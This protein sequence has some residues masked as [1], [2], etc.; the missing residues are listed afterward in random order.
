MR[1]N[2]KCI[3]AKTLALTLALTTVAT[4]TP[5][6][7]AE[8]AKKPALSKKKVTVNVKKSTKIKIKNVKAKKVRK[9]TVKIDK[10]KIASVKKNGKTAFTIT[11]KKA[12]KANVTAKIKVGKKTTTLKVKVTVKAASVDAKES[13]APSVA[14]SAS[15]VVSVAPSAP[16]TPAGTTAPTKQPKPTVRPL[17][18]EG[19]EGSTTLEPRPEG[20]PLVE[21]S[22]NFDEGVPEEWFPRYNSDDNTVT[23]ESTDEAVEGKAMHVTGRKK[24]WNG[25]GIDMS[26]IGTL[27]ATY[28][29]KFSAKVPDEF[30]EDLDGE[31]VALRVSGGYKVTSA[32]EEK[33][34]NYPADTDYMISADEWRDF[35]VTFVAPSAFYSYTFYFE[36]NGYGAFDLLFDNITLTRTVAPAEADLTLASLK[37]SYAPY[38]GIFGV[39]SNY[40]ELM[41][42]NSLE[43]IKHHFNSVT[44][45]NSMKVDALVG[46]ETLLQSEANYILSD[47]YATYAENKDANGNVI[48]PEFTLDEIDKVLKICYDNG[49]KIRIHAPMWHQ[50]MPKLFFCEQYD[51]EKPVITNKDV[52]L[53]REEMFI[54]NVYQYILTSPY[55]EVVSAIDV[56]NEYTHMHN[57][58]EQV[59]SDNWWK[60]SFGTEMKTDCEYVKKAFVWA[61][62]VLELC[63]RTDISL[64]YNDYNTYEAKIADQIVELVNNIN[65]VDEVNTVGKICDGVGMQCHFHDQHGT[66]EN[67]AAALA[68]F[69]ANDFEI[70][71]TELDITNL[72]TVTAETDAETKAEVEAASAEMYAGIMTAILDAKAAGA[73]INSVTLWGTIDAAS[74]REDRSPLLFGTDI[75]D[76]KPA[77]DA[78]INAALN[79]GK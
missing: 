37:E 6:N 10:K 41:N 4:A 64:I 70:Q 65:K 8:A 52:I 1:K 13:A 29:V 28:K 21:E 18:T 39:A 30:S 62:E 54:R 5:A 24:G 3:V 58:S 22:W 27:G 26:A 51:E 35:E 72:G 44:M 50:Q 32:D 12:G 78:V 74:W 42:E 68:K 69:A 45:G 33:Y 11:G 67:F 59:G 43:F 55:A 61:N 49:L 23:I 38:F 16:A 20:T 73:K 17:A 40:S 9:L 46:K 79:Y 53:A 56:V 77:F 15:P 2:V 25:V 31:D 75:S 14:P 36:T 48:V 7:E 63:E 19:E 47:E 57:I 71:I 60:Y 34:E 66:V 76:K